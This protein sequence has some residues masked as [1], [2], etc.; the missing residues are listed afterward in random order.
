MG[1]LV[2]DKNPDYL[3]KAFIASGLRLLDKKLVIAGSN[4][5]DQAYV[6]CLHKLAEGYSNILFTGSVYG[7]DKEKLLAECMAFCI[8]STLEGLPLRYLRPCPMAKSALLPIF[9]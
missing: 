2:Q 9:K 1:R 8:P 4:D 5:A 6:D 7:D 3:I